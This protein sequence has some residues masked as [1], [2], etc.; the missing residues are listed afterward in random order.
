[1]TQSLK[2]RKTTQKLIDDLLDSEMGLDFI[3]SAGAYTERGL[4]AKLDRDSLVHILNDAR[5]RY[6]ESREQAILLARYVVQAEYQRRNGQ[7]EKSEATLSGLYRTMRLRNLKYTT[8]A[9]EELQ[10]EETEMATEETTNGTAAAAKTPGSK[11]TK[12]SAS[13]KPAPKAKGGKSKEQ[14]AKETAERKSRLE[15]QI[16][17]LKKMPTEDQVPK[18]ALEICK[19]IH[20]AGDKIVVSTLVSRM[21]GV[22]QTKQTMMAIWSFYRAKLVDGGFVKIEDARE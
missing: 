5:I 12:K 2:F 6:P 16:V 13:K 15:N 4:L 19:L 18:Q 3:L 21:E 1:M 10:K 11:A 22:V 8:E 14:K 7:F 17:H 9:P 20:K